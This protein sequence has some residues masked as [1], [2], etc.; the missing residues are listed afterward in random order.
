ML[1]KNWYKELKIIE[2]GNNQ[3][4]SWKEKTVSQKN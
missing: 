2:D 1:H 3:K 4:K